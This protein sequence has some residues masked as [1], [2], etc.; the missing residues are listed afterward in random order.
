MRRRPGSQ[1]ADQHAPLAVAR[2]HTNRWRRL[3]C[4]QARWFATRWRRL[5]T[6]PSSP[7]GHPCASCW[8]TSLTWS[9]DR[10]E[11]DVV[12]GHYIGVENTPYYSLFY[13]P[14]VSDSTSDDLGDNPVQE[15]ERAAY[16]TVA[17]SFGL[18]P[19]YTH[20]PHSTRTH[21]P[22]HAST[23]MVTPLARYILYYVVNICLVRLVVGFDSFCKQQ[24]LVKTRMH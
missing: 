3:R 20:M 4:R 13:L 8:G 11:F 19:F 6:R 23:T 16:L 2:A 21:S 7:A 24:G 22:V 12:D 5:W 15:W 14:A 18:L 10:P 1:P 9:M 17:F